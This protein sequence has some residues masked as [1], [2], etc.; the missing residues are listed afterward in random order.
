MKGLMRRPLLGGCAMPECRTCGEK[1]G[2]DEGA[3]S[4]FE[5]LGDL[6]LESA[7]E[8]PDRRCPACREEFG[9]WCLL[10]FDG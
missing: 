3:A 10:G 9:I 2:E 6:F 5:T 4:P 1:Y 8:K 7:G